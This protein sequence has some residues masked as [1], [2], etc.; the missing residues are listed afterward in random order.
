M[1]EFPSPR[2]ILTVFERQPGKTFRLRELVVELGLRS[3]QAR[4]LKNALKDLSRHRRIVYLKKNHFALVGTERKATGANLGDSRRSTADS[5][6]IENRPSKIGNGG[7][8]GAAPQPGANP[9][10]RVPNPRT[11]RGANVVGGRLI[12]HRDGYGFVVPDAPLA[13][14]D[15]DIYISADGMGSAMNGDRVE[16]QVLRAKPDGR[17]EGRILSVTDRAQKTVV[18][19][20]HCGQRYNFVMPFD[21]RIPF[22]IVIPRGE[23]WPREQFRISD[24]EFRR[25]HDRQIGGEPEQ[26]VQISDS[27]FRKTR[28]RQFGGESEGKTARQEV[29]SRRLTQDL[30]GLVVDVEITS[31]PRPAA[32][33][34]GRVVEILGRRQDFGVD[35]EIVIRKFHLPHRF[36]AEVL[37]EAGAAPQSIAEQD[38]AGRRD[39]RGLP[40]VTI[41]G[42]TAKDFDD[43]VRVERRA[44]GNYLL[45]VHIADVAHYVRPGTALDREARLRGTSV[46]FPD[47]A[48]PMLP[49]ELSNGICSLNPHVDRLVM[50]A[51][52]EID[53]Q[54][55]IVEY[56]LTPG[57]ICSAE[58]MTYTAVRDILSGEQAALQRYATLCPDFKLME[59]L[60]LILNRRRV[61]RGS[62]DFDL[63][64]PLIEFDEHGRMVGITRSERNVAHRLIEEFMLAANESVARYLES[65]GIPS[66]YRIHE[67][68]EAKKVLEFE[69]I[70]ATFGYSLGVEMPA[71]QRFRPNKRDERDRHMRFIERVE[72]KELEITPRH[73]QRLTQRLEGKPEERILSYLMLRSLKQARYSEENVGHFAL[74]AQT[75]THFTSPI[76][77][78]PDLIVHRI[79]KAALERE[80]GSARVA[81]DEADRPASGVARQEAPRKRRGAGAEKRH[82]PAAFHPGKA[83]TGQTLPGG[84]FVL[85]QEL[86]SLG[87]ATSEAE[88]RA[89]D[90]ERE[91][92]EWKKVSF[93][94]QHVGDEFEALIISL[95]KFGFFVELTDLFVEGFVALATLGDDYYVYRERQRAIIGQHTHRAFHLGERVRVR[96]DRIDQSGNKLEFSL[97]D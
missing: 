93:M 76:R 54:G 75:Y 60:A 44:N 10:S 66:L 23:E 41:D 40:I 36:P 89:A 64:E 16:V 65:R 77:R 95:I 28:D 57:I 92:I 6:A 29:I 17:R 78:Y 18:G 52:M 94:A 87:Q 58:R 82:A 15:Q 26:Q 9:E 34:R 81:G 3:S 43:A 39:F 69:E 90:A 53:P 48:V 49:L 55:R 25:T 38:L 79:L 73:Y 14:T 30:E 21:Q 62:I 19:Q 5:Q 1:R 45:H 91:L 68:P 71:A 35:V 22:E 83:P 13:G 67:K 46:Y 31:Y 2:E 74:A 86:H 56:E 84:A 20:F 27:E 96:L 37:A 88:R 47:R 85:P 50:S 24:S 32:L 61:E 59:E 72:T 7:R 8:D 33:P 97:A 63:P 4:D 11:S 70:A 51:L 80:G 42:E 12:G